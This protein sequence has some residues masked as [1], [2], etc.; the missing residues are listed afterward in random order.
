MWSALQK[1]IK[2][3]WTLGLTE[4]FDLVLEFPL[5]GQGLED[6]GKQRGRVLLG[7]LGPA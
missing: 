3:D 4:E 5:D 6:T 1:K 7:L 2:V